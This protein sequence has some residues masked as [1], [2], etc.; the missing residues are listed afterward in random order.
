LKTVGEDHAQDPDA[1]IRAENQRQNEI[2]ASIRSLKTNIL[3]VLVII[4]SAVMT[5]PMPYKVRAYVI[6]FLKAFL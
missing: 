6:S 4:I 1:R 3:I 2:R 5:D